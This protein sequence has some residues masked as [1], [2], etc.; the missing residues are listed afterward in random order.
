MFGGVHGFNPSGLHG[1]SFSVRV[2]YEHNTMAEQ[3]MQFLWGMIL[4]NT[5]MQTIARYSV[6]YIQVEN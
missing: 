4:C 6:M 3:Q 1:Q 5:Q 2:A